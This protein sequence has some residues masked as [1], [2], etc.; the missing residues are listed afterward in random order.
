M[1]DKLRFGAR[2][3]QKSQGELDVLFLNKKRRKIVDRMPCIDRLKGVVAFGFA[4]QVLQARQRVHKRESQRK[5]KKTKLTT[6]FCLQGIIWLAILR[7]QPRVEC[8]NCV[9]TTL[10][11]LVCVQAVLWSSDAANR[12]TPLTRFAANH[13]LQDPPAWNEGCQLSRA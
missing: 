6:T 12:T 13:E 1:L 10:N 3:P 4:V 5:A 7:G 2:G 9:E 11:A 8:K